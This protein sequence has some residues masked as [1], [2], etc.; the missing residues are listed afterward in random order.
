MMH[1]TGAAIVGAVIFIA[2]TAL[3]QSPPNPQNPAPPTTS[4]APSPATRAARGPVASQLDEMIAAVFNL[5][6]GAGHR[7]G[8]LDE[9]TK[10]LQAEVDYW[11]A[12]C[13]PLPGC[14]KE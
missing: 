1:R 7:I 3:A 14:A 10:E 11:R 6:V 8:L 9:K 5:G 2:R 4:P 13:G 12:W